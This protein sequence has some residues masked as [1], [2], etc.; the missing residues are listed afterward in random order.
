MLAEL[1]DRADNVGI[2]WTSTVCHGLPWEEIH[3]K[4]T[5]STPT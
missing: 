4:P 2:D 1:A 5:R 3:E